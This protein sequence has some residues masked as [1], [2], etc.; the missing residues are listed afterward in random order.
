MVT[1]AFRSTGNIEF[2]EQSSGFCQ[3]V[4]KEMSV[5]DIKDLEGVSMWAKIKALGYLNLP[6]EDLKKVNI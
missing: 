6:T 3:Q 4:L 1:E 5:L 2:V